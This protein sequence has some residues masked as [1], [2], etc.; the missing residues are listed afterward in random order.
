MNRIIYITLYILAVTAATGCKKYLSVVPKGKIIPQQ[1]SDYRLLLNQVNSSGESN[2]FVNS[3]SNDV[4]IGDDMQVTPFSTSF[5]SADEQNALTFA[6]NI[7][8]DFEEDPDWDALYNQIYVTNLVISQVMAS[9]G[10]AETDKRELLSEALVHRAFA[11]LTLVN[12]YA[13]PYTPTTAATDPG[14]PLRT[15]LDFQESLKRAS[16]QETYD[17]IGNDLRL[18]VAGLPAKPQLNYTYRPVQATAY[19]LLARTALYMNRIDSALLYA[20]SSLADYNFLI[21]YNSL[22]PSPLFPGGL[23]YPIGLQNSEL[24][25]DKSVVSG[26]SFFYADPGLISL[27]DKQNDLRI[28]TQYFN[29]ALFGLTYGYISAQ[30]SGKTPVKGPTVAEVYLIRAECYA[31]GGD[32]SSAMNDLNTLRSNRYVTGSNYTLTAASQAEALSNVKAERRRELA[33]EGLRLF[34]IK[35]YNAY[36]NDNISV[37]HTLNGKTYTLPAG[38]PRFVLPIGRKYISQNAEIVQNAR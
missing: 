29:D 24:L 15:G 36:D 10:G 14:V 5:Y 12:L 4:L 13:K 34:D 26:T 3:Y 7:Y 38:D 18:S 17:L 9:L 31:R 27:Y 37:I 19:A 1:T 20:N 2:G 33:F 6:D 28:I 8:Q 25:L 23:K 32:L 35:R 22:P 21:N 11:Y 30:W 16:V